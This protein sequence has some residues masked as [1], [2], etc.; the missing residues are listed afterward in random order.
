VI[1]GEVTATIPPQVSDSLKAEG[2]RLVPLLESL[3]SWG[4]VH[5]EI[6]P[7]LPRPAAGSDASCK[8]A[9]TL[10]LPDRESCDRMPLEDLREESKDQVCTPGS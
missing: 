3:C 1:S 5:F 7:N 10:R 8:P 2:K 6:Q 9:A 4:R